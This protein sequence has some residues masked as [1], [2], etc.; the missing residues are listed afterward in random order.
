M[1]KEEL[2]LGLEIY[3]F[4]Y[5]STFAI[6]LWKTEEVGKRLYAINN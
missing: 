6:P 4:L 5:Y 1:K 2:K 3:L